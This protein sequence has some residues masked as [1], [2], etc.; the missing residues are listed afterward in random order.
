MSCAENDQCRFMGW[1]LGSLIF[2]CNVI[3]FVWISVFKSF[4]TEDIKSL[5]ICKKWKFWDLFPRVGHG[6]GHPNNKGLFFRSPYFKNF[7]LS[8]HNFFKKESILYITCLQQHQSTSGTP[9]IHKGTD[10]EVS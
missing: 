7:T 8:T 1:Y 10:D 4:T 3:S 6:I 9:D 5:C 2:T